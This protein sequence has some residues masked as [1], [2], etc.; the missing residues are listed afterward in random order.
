MNIKN[1][2]LALAVGCAMA[3]SAQPAQSVQAQVRSIY[4]EAQQKVQQQVDEPMM[5]RV[6]T[7]KSTRMMGGVG[8]CETT[9]E[10][11]C[12]I[13]DNASEDRYAGTEDLHPY[14]VREKF[15]RSQSL[16]GKEYSEYL[17]HPETGKLIFYYKQ[18]NELADGTNEEVEET[19]YY[20]DSQGRYAGGNV[21]RKRKDSGASVP[22]STQASAQAAAPVVAKA[23]RYYQA[24]QL[25]VNEP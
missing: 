23:S 6:T 2:T 17:Y 1:F 11:F 7:V 3:A 15:E 14:F 13:D 10:F 4:T 9:T 22:A 18:S 20:F 12:D 5:G 16:I 25:L 21:Q 8:L 24:L 19:R